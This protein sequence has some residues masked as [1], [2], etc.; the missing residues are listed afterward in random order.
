MRF[1]NR[2]DEE[3]NIGLTPLIDVVFILLIFFM[4]TTT[5]DQNSELKIDLPSASGDPGSAQ[6]DTLEITIDGQGQFFINKVKIVSSA[7]ETVF[8][9]IQKVLNGRKD[10]PVI[11]QADAQTPH[12]SVVTAMDTVG[13]LGITRL[14]IATS[15][16]TK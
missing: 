10:I 2:K 11:I 1:Q 9:A 14:S 8:L 4:V 15:I 3:V 13:K 12:H 6:E 7:P 16:P 5:F